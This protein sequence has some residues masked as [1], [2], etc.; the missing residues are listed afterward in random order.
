MLLSLGSYAQFCYT[1]NWTEPSLDSMLIYVS[2]A[3]LDGTN[4]QAGDAIGVFDGTEC[5]GLGVLTGELTGAP[6][7]LV[8]ETSRD[9]AGTVQRDGFINGNP[10]SFRFCSGGSVVNPSVSPTYLTNGPNFAINDSCVVELSAV[11]TAPTVT[12]IPDTVATEDLLY[13]SSITATDI[14]IG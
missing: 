12:S 10:I 8:I 5:V 7:Y 6:T 11:N 3:T 1:P 2:M 13:S 9:N 14:D 4:L